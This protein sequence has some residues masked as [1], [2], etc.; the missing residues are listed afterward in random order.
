MTK[1]IH[2]AGEA[3]T[4]GITDHEPP[5]TGA[6]PDF[7]MIFNLRDVAAVDISE[8]SLPAAGKSQN[9]KRILIHFNAPPNAG[10]CVFYQSQASLGSFMA[11]PQSY[12]S[13]PLSDAYFRNKLGL[14]NR[15]RHFGRC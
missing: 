10:S 2:S 15:R 12:L 13:E 11:I 14:P 8:L 5:L 4:N 6:S 1:K 9:G 7:T 3:Q